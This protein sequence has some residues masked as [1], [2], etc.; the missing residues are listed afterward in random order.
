[1][2][3]ALT[4]GFGPGVP[5]SDEATPEIGTVWNAGHIEVALATRVN[6]RRLR[7]LWRRRHGNRATPLLVLAPSGDSDV[8]VLGPQ[9]PDD[10]VR[11]VAMDALLST[12][13]ELQAKSR[14]DAVVA[15]QGALERLDRAGVPGILIRGLLTRHVLTRRLRRNRPQEWERLE[16]AAAKV[17][18]SRSWRENLAAL[19]YD[20]E[21]RPSRGHVLRHEGR[22][23]AVVHPLPDPTAFARMTPEGSTPEGLL[24]ADCRAE[25]VAWGLLATNTR[26]RLFPAETSV[27]AATARYVEMD[28]TAT[29]TDDWAYI[30]LLA[31]ESLEPG[32]LLEQL[33]QEAERLGNEL[34]EDVEQRIREQVLPAIARGLGDHQRRGGHDLSSP[35]SRQLNEDATLLLVFRLIFLLWLE[36]RGYLP[37]ASSAYSLHSATQ[38]LGDARVQG[39]AFDARATTL[40]D[41]FMTLVKAMRSGNT[42]W[43]LPA[44]D[45]DLF[46]ADALEG[47]ELLEE[48][49]MADA[50]FG[51]ALAA[52]GHDPE[53]EDAEAGVDFG[54]LEIAHL[55]RIYEGLLSLRLSLATEPMA[56]DPRV[57]RWMPA[58]DAEAEVKRGDLFF[59]TES[60]GRKAAGV[61]YTPQLLVRHLVDRA[62]LPALEGHL[63]RV[64]AEPNARRAAAMLFDFKVLDPAMGSAHFLADA[65]DRIADRIGTF[66]AEHPLKPVTALIDELRAESAWEGRIEDGDLLR[67]LVLKRCIYGVDLSRMAVEVGKVSLWL[68]SFVPGLSLAYLGHNLKQGDALVGVAKADVLAD[69]GPLFIDVHAGGYGAVPAIPKALTRAKTLAG[70]VAETADRTPEEVASSR[71]IDAELDE[72]LSGLT[73]LFDVW[74][75][76]P[77]GLQGARG[78]LATAAVDDLVEGRTAK[79]EE[80]YLHPALNMAEKLFFFQWLAEFPE[81]F[82]RDDPGFDVVIGNPPWEELTVEELAFY[83]LHDPGIRGLRAEADRR[84]RIEELLKRYPDLEK[85]FEERKMAL[86]EK[87]RFFG[88]QGGYVAQGSGDIDLYKL[89]SERYRSLTRERGWLGV[90]LPRSAFLVDG[91]RGFRRWLFGDGEVRRLDFI[92]NSARWAFDMEPRYTLTLVAARRTAPG[93]DSVVRMT[94]PSPSQA[95]FERAS[96]SDG[97]PVT[98][99]RLA[100]WTRLVDSPGYEVPLLPS[101]EA[102]AVFNKL[103][104]GPRFA[105]GYRGVWSAFPVAELHETADKK[106]FSHEEGVPVWKGRSFDQ[107]DP[108]GADPAGFADEAEAMDKLQAKRQRS[109]VFRTRFPREATEDPN[110]HPFHSVRVAFRDVSRA[111]DSRTVRACMIPPRTFLTNSAPYLVFP[112][113]SARA[114]ALVLGILNSLPFDWQA[115]RFVEI[116]LNFYVLN[117]LCL[118]PPGATDV[119]A[120]AE[121]AARLS[122]VDDRF[123]EFAEEAG[124]VCGSL[125]PE[126]R[127]R[128]HAEID[129]LVA[130]AYGLT[131]EDL[132]VVFADFTQNALPDARRQEIRELLETTS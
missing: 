85:E 24:V 46:A 96:A 36:G 83:A 48:A 105:E 132:E 40:W 80:R 111:T 131:A 13:T 100:S 54:G 51:P 102:V 110:T 82:V 2:E 74:T 127:A 124:L 45:G 30:G 77:F 22:P 62:V 70:R 109:R 53:G 101:A 37:T 106:L 41:R 18:R 73:H 122:C 29:Q 28:L 115:R 17:T 107:F 50:R 21:G 8:H 26:F 104:A 93:P 34:R 43:G 35:E 130:K 95:E 15:L 14:R 10:P 87:R 84:R 4:T 47:A 72:V 89:F 39:P 91:A 16:E 116:H 20:I 119:D 38:L 75:A 78:W 113:G 7:A 1:M 112:E 66:L 3:K 81:V 56:Y 126:D 58:G 69:L 44:Y 103:R 55:G 88:P 64:A 97:I 76:E 92:L 90:V 23:I 65:L 67:R 86:E 114:A 79:G 11:E 60:G 63:Q 25:N 125:E 108:H 59:Q 49:G 5:V 31:P 12:L 94:G 6:E 120:I 33:V 128:L 19:G 71:E 99:E 123:A 98:Y 32:G 57:D 9:R 121:R 117:L 129:A 52:L 61:Y 42:A 68:A 118:P 27:G